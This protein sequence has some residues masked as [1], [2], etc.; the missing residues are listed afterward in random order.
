[1]QKVVIGM[2]LV[3]LLF[4]CSVSPSGTTPQEPGTEPK[5]EK[6]DTLKILAIGNSF[7]SDA[8]DDNLYDLFKAAGIPVVIGNLNATG[9]SLE[10]HWKRI[11]E[12]K[13]DYTFIRTKRGGRTSTE[14]CEIGAILSSDSWNIVSI[15]QASSKSADKDSY[16]P[17][18]KQLKE[19]IESKTSAKVAF[20][21]TWAYENSAFENEPDNSQQQ[22]YENIVAAVN[23][24]VK[25]ADIKIVIPTGTAVQNARTTYLETSLNR[26]YLHLSMTTGRYLASC[27]W[28]ET[29]SGKEVT[30]NSYHPESITPAT[31]EI[32]QKA[33]HY[34]CLTPDSVTPMPQY[35]YQPE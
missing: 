22:M 14:A 1:M 31:A 13:A 3:S 19:F 7:S 21:Q 30:G 34:A 10:D 27:V 16:L 4:S 25:E 24:A 9:S 35:Q 20:H 26:D 17:Y 11:S 32:C 33:A 28:F 15:Q 6:T 12:Q 23:A 18:A 29:L 8:V 5:G 2:T